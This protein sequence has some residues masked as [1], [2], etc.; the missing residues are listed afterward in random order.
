MPS[1][2]LPGLP[3][4]YTGEWLDR[5]SAYLHVRNASHA[6]CVEAYTTL[7]GGTNLLIHAGA[8]D[9]AQALAMVAAALL[10]RDQDQR[11]EQAY[12]QER[13]RRPD[14]ETVPVQVWADIDTGIAEMVRYLNTL[15][16]LRTDA[17]CQ[18]T[19]G[20]GGPNP[21]RAQVLAH[22]PAAL[23]MRLQEEFDVTLLGDDWGYLHPR[24][25]AALRTRQT[26][27]GAQGNG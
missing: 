11:I 13:Q 22:W 16:G 8:I 5:G 23:R 4:G 12:E 19:I 18:G 15:P 7:D 1:E 3:D 9:R 27:D 21:Y 24:D 20:E 26:A 14:H 6:V 2:Q 10:V 25:E 17:S